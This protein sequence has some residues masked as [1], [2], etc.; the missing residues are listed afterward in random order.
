VKVSHIKGTQ[1][2]FMHLNLGD[3][4]GQQFDSGR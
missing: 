2:N 1:I 4:E 3:D